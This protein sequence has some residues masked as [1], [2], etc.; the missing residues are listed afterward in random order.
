MCDALTA[1]Y[2]ISRVTL[3]V[4]LSL[5]WSMIVRRQNMYFLC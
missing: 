2:Y 4:K 1:Y 3:K 5:I